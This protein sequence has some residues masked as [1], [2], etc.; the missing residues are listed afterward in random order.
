VVTQPTN[1]YSQTLMPSLAYTLSF[2]I[3]LMARVAAR[4]EPQGSE[5]EQELLL[6]TNRKIVQ[7]SEA[8]DKADEAEEFQ[9]VAMRLR[10]GL[11]A[12]V[13]ELVEDIEIK[14]AEERPKMADFPAWNELIANAVAPRSSGCRTSRPSRS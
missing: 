8:F 11:L 5:A 6:V 13:R 4:R 14:P 10:E 9:A 2:H 12:L 1:L 7:A 3:G